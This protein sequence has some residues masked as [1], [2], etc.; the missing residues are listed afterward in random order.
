[1][2][3]SFSLLL[4]R[5]ENDFLVYCHHYMSYPYYFQK[6]LRSQHHNFNMTSLIL[7]LI[8]HKTPRQIVQNDHVEMLYVIFDQ[9]SVDYRGA[10]RNYNILLFFTQKSPLLHSKVT[11]VVTFNKIFKSKWI[12]HEVISYH[13]QASNTLMKILWFAIDLLTVYQ[14]LIWSPKSR[15]EY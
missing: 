5:S 6:F 8:T 3:K 1:M 9:Y 10:E 12:L 15:A 14:N 11:R 13:L 4:R 7:W 2:K